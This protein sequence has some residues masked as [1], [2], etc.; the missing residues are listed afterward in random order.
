MEQLNNNIQTIKNLIK[1]VP[2]LNDIPLV[3]EFGG[4][5][6]DIEADMKIA[7]DAMKEFNT[8]RDNISEKIG[9]NGEKINKILSM[10]EKATGSSA[11]PSS[12]NRGSAAIGKPRRL[13]EE[14]LDGYSKRNYNKN[15]TKRYEL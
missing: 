12:R 6:K 14:K 7:R 5:V 8:L 2:S 15:K 4:I 10:V 3:K 13:V 11:G 9:K 1:T